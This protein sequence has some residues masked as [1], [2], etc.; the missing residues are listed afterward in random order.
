MRQL[1]EKISSQNKL[2]LMILIL[3]NFVSLISETVMNVALPSIISEFSV[4]TSTAQ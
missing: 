2:I 4:S 1:E 3:G